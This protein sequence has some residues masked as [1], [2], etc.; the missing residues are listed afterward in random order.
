MVVPRPRTH[1]S[2]YPSVLNSI[3]ST[4]ILNAHVKGYL[5]TKHA[6]KDSRSLRSL[7]T[8]RNSK[9]KIAKSAEGKSSDVDNNSGLMNRARAVKRQRIVRLEY[10]YS[11]RNKSRGTHLWRGSCQKLVD[12]WCGRLASGSCSVNVGWRQWETETKG[13]SISS[14]SEVRDGLVF[15]PPIEDEVL[16]LLLI[17]PEPQLFELFCRLVS[18]DFGNRSA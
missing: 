4:E 10:W 9:V 8:P 12:N 14:N 15:V 16:N 11:L 7:T 18:P 17:E 1:Y 13:G 5:P 2:K 3:L 6:K